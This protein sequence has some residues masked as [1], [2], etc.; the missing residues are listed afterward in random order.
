[1][2]VAVLDVLRGDLVAVEPPAD[3][4]ACLAMAFPFTFSQTE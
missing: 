1:L 2:V 4:V 3:L